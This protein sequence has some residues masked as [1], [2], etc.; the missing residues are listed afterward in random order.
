MLI[1]VAALGGCG[2]DGRVTPEFEA[3]DLATGAAVSSGELRGQT[4]LLATF[5][6]W[7]APCERELPELEAA[8][9]DIEA[10][11][12]RVIAVNVDAAGV[13]ASEVEAMIGR[14]APS[15]EVWRDDRSEILAAYGATFMP[16]SVVIDADGD[17]VRDWN[18]SLDPTGDEFLAA[19]GD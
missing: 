18:G 5:A 17:V 1:V 12:V 4:T 16:Y 19:I 14:L 10:A 8:L 11:G 2:D 15:V 9:P 7:C 13:P 6:T 3:V